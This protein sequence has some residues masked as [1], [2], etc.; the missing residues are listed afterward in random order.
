VQERLLKAGCADE[1]IALFVEPP[2]AETV[3]LRRAA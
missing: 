1:A 3:E 2:V